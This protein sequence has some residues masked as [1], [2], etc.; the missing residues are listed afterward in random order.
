M[1]P[2]PIPIS[3]LYRP[4]AALS[5]I[6]VNPG[7]DEGP[8]YSPDGRYLAYRTQTRAGYESD[9]WRLAVIDLQSGR[10]TTL[11][12]SLDR[13]VETF[14]W[15][16]D[17][18]RIFFTIDEHGTNPLMMISVGGGGVRTIAEGPTTI[19]SMQ[20]TPHDRIIFTPNKAV[21]TRLKFSRLLRKAVAGWP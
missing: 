20:F 19:S 7:A 12:D 3:S 9:Q 8:L 2:A 10:G 5:T 1:P 21:P 17:S 18:Q 11:T 16:S 13:W 4:P 15:A 14:T 6:N